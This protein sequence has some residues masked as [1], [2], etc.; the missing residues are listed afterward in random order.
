MAGKRG[1]P[2]F[3]KKDEDLKVTEKKEKTTQI[4]EENKV[5]SKAKEE[6]PV[7]KPDLNRM[8]CVKNIA[9]SKLIYKSKRQIGYTIEWAK[10]GDINYMELSEFINLRNSDRRFVTEPWVR[11]IE[12]DEIEILKYANVLQYYKDILDV[13]NTKDI[14]LLDF[15]SFK[16][17]FDKL[18]KSVKNTVAEQAAQML[19]SGELDSIKI[20]NYIEEVLEID[21]DILMK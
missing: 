2:N 8:I 5:L 20:K 21:L 1:N 13:D 6:I 4:K 11:I 12:D 16:K 10:T 19:K 9:R 17:K 7:W 15:E 14:L 3:I 18:P